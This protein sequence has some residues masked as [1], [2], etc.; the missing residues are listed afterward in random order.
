M[1]VENNRGLINVVSDG[2]DDELEKVLWAI[3][4]NV[5]I[6]ANAEGFNSLSGSDMPGNESEHVFTATASCF[7]S[8]ADL[9]G[10]TIW[11]PTGLRKPKKIDIK[12][13]LKA[14]AKACEL[15]YDLIGNE[16]AEIYKKTKRII[17]KPSKYFWI[18]G[19]VFND[20]IY[21]DPFDGK[22]DVVRIDNEKKLY[23]TSFCVDQLVREQTPYTDKVISFATNLTLDERKF[24]KTINRISEGKFNKMEECAL[25]KF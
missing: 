1:D 22:P 5:Q 2:L 24:K 9:C 6:K 19:N 3:I 20:R 12:K 4:Q 23:Y 10:S 14:E 21:H 8:G 7:H 25:W 11:S 15:M 18:V 16:Q 13:N 17:T